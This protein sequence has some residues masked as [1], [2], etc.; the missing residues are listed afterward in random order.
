MKVYSVSYNA[1]LGGTWLTWFINQ[2]EG[3]QNYDAIFKP[4]KLDYSVGDELMWYWK[5]YNWNETVK[6]NVWNDKSNVVYK[7]FPSHDWIGV[8]NEFEGKD[9]E[10]LLKSNTIG[11]VVPYVNEELKSEFVKRNVHTFNTTV[12]RAVL[13]IDWGR[14]HC[15]SNDVNRNCYTKYASLYNVVTIDM[16][17]LLNCNRHEYARLLKLIHTPEHPQYEQMCMEYKSNVFP[18]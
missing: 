9:D 10:M 18:S 13:N 7:L 15:T 12:E 6:R 5:D 17:K 3:F 2:H 11:I 4:D 8:R 14:I 1:G 16:G